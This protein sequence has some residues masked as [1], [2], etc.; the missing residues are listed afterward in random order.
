[1]KEKIEQD[2]T[3]SANAM[4][5]TRQAL[6]EEIAQAAQI[7]IEALES[8]K[9][10]L[11]CGNGGSAAQAQHFIAELIVRFETERRALPGIS[12]TT[13]TSNLTA[14]ANDYGYDTVFARQLEALGQEGDVLVGLTTSGN[15]PNVVEAIKVAQEKGMKTIILNGKDGGTIADMQ[16]TVNLIVPHTRTAHIQ[17]VHIAI[18][19]ILCALIDKTFS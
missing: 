9:K 10:I 1:M 19:H 13:D 17:E 16:T 14:G 5:Q 18:I 12:L 6:G 3:E 11:A 4:I 7:L 8:G 15:S 2:L